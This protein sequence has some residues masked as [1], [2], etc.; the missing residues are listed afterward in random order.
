LAGCNVPEGLGGTNEG[1][2]P[3]T[4]SVGKFFL[5]RKTRNISNDT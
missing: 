2:I 1:H 5:R 3:T 4:K